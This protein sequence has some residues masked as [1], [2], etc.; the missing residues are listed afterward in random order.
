MT[1]E[2]NEFSGKSSL[3][4]GWNVNFRILRA[5]TINKRFGFTALIIAQKL[6]FKQGSVTF[7]AQLFA[8]GSLG[9]VKMLA[10]GTFL[11]HSKYFRIA[12]DFATI[13][14]NKSADKSSALLAK[15]A[16]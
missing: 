1:D 6:A 15:L 5:F 16:I 7:L 12:S 11:I 9:Q 3:S 4:T 13:F 14:I 2:A 8:I 10:F